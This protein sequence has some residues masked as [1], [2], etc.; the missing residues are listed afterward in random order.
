MK[1]YIFILFL[2][3]VKCFSQSSKDQ[4]IFLSVF[5]G[6][7]DSIIVIAKQSDGY[8]RLEALVSE[9][10]IYNKA[11]P[12]KSIILTDTEVLFLKNEI[13]KNEKYNFPET[14]FPDAILISSDT[15][16]SYASNKV[17]KWRKEEAT[18][19]ESK[20][21]IKIF[22]FIREKRYSFTETYVHFFSKPIYFRNDTL[23][24]LYHAD[25]CCFNNGLG[26]CTSA[27]IYKKDNDIWE[28]YI[29]IT[30]GCY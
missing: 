4:Q 13:N 6:N 21:T 3:V 5:V 18:V 8:K 20:D 14:I 27:Y 2:F 19:F 23:C 7:K 16:K 25:L 28:K 15:V 26:G 10:N 12:E 1:N 30:F 9:K 17:K 11:F 24:I 29:T 22:K